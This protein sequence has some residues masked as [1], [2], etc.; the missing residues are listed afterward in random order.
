MYRII[1][2]S[3]LS[4]SLLNAVIIE[5]K[6]NLIIYAIEHTNLN[7]NLVDIFMK[8][9]AIKPNQR[10]PIENCQAVMVLP[11]ILHQKTDDEW[12]IIDIP[13]ILKS[14]NK[15]FVIN[16]NLIFNKHFSNSN[17]KRSFQ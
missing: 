7:N 14:N 9:I 16:D 3:S 10:V 17:W 8:A 12:I 6:S 15:K 1:L 11:A 2:I 5:N 13:A 4:M